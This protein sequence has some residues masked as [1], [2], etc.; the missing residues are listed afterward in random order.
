ME[1]AY[2][3]ARSRSGKVVIHVQND[4]GG[5]VRGRCL[6]MFVMLVDVAIPLP[7]IDVMPHPSVRAPL[8]AAR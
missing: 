7:T 6:R 4:M 3:V 1:R 2:V 8:P 5:W